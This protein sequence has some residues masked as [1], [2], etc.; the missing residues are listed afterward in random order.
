MLTLQAGG[1][2]NAFG[3]GMV[4]PFMFIYLHNVRGIELGVAGLIVGTHAVMS[5]VAGP[6][7]GSQIDRFGGKRMLALALVVLAVGYAGYT[8]VHEPWQGFLVALVSGIGVGGFWPAQSTL[9]TGLTPPDQRPSAFAMQRVVMNLG[10]GLGAL[11]GGFIAT[12]DSP[13]SFTALFLLDAAT[14]LVY[15]CVMLALVPEPTRAVGHGP[16]SGSYRDVL[17][18]RPFV[19][20]IALNAL[21]I[22]AGFSGFDVLPVYAK[23][24]AG[25]SERQIG[26]LFLINTLVIVFTQL[27]TARLVRGRRRM[28]TLGLFGL[29]WAGAWLLV[30]IAGAVTTGAA[31]GVLVVVMVVFAVGQCLHG[32]VAGPLAADLAEPRLIGRYMALNALSWNIGFALGPALGGAG[33]ALSPNGV[34]IAASALCAIGAACT[35]VVEGT[36]PSR[37][38]RTPVPAAASA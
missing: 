21:F 35:L 25:L 1:L 12:S 15:A 34:W 10:I 24:E 36:L 37:A 19:A 13:G 17:R 38:R 7:F 16:G 4:I 11:A 32:A 31:F 20:V 26:L 9:I 27:P 28:P 14:F 33:L 2:V 29:L 22:F 8:L 3:N 23:N 6:V 5:I 18:H 30:P